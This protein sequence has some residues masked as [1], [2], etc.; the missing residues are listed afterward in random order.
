MKRRGEAGDDGAGCVGDGASG[1][2]RF[3]GRT[4][5][6][7]DHVLANSIAGEKP[8][9]RPGAGEEWLATTEHDGVEV[10]SIL[11][12][13]TK[14]CQASRQVWPGNV[15]LPDELSLQPPYHRLDII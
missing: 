11:I 15:D 8:E 1:K 6:Q 4:V 12:D 10:E 13:K 9:R 7:P 5:R 2:V 14:I 3:S